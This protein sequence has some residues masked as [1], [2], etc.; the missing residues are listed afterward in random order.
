MSIQAYI[1]CEVL[2]FYVVVLKNVWRRLC[3]GDMANGVDMAKFD[4]PSFKFEANS[5]GG[6]RC[7]I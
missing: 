4:E 3:C 7:L 6:V 5:L 1:I 2:L